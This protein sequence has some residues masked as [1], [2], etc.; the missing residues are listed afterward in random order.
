MEIFL[1]IV[2]ASAVIFFGVLISMGNERQ[3]KALDGLREQIVLWAVQDLK[4]KREGL[5]RDIRVK[6][7]V[8]WLN[9]VS[10]KAAG[11]ELGLQIVEVFDEPQ[12]IVCQASKIGATIIFSPLSPKE[13]KVQISTGKGKLDVLRTHPLHQ[14]SPHW[15]VNEMSVLNAGI[16]FDIELT[17]AW[18]ALTGREIDGAEVLFMYIQ[19]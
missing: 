17:L 6:D 11:R 19:G 4:I 13:V 10:R 12:A 16:L 7:P 2:V 5:A 14:Y 15:V 8:H 9:E 3:R 18:Q 1:A